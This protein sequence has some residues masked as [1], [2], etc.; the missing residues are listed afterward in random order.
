MA[1]NAAPTHCQAGFDLRFGPAVTR[2][3]SEWNSR[4]TDCARLI[5]EPEDETHS[6]LIRAGWHPPSPSY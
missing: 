5:I 6:D 4:K 1:A 3:A 2:E